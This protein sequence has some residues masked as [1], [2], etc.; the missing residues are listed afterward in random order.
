MFAPYLYGGA[1]RQAVVRFKYGGAPHLGAR[2][3][4]IVE[5]DPEDFNQRV[6]GPAVLEP[7][8]VSISNLAPAAPTLLISIKGVQGMY[9]ARGCAG[10]HAGAF[11][12]ERGAWFRRLLPGVYALVWCVVLW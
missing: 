3:R 9:D 7:V 1:L 11:Q 5:V 6:D 2:R 10:C 8:L 4:D 12:N